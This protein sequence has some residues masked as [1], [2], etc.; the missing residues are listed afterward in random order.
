MSCINFLLKAI[1]YILVIALMFAI[2][3]IL[4]CIGIVGT[5]MGMSMDN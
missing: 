3:P 4:G 1:L 2:H 5:I